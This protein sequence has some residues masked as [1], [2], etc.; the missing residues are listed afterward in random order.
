MIRWALVRPGDYLARVEGVGF[1]QSGG[2][3]WQAEQLGR[4]AWFIM[5]RQVRDGFLSII[6]YPASSFYE[7]VIPMLSIVVGTLFVLGLAFAIWRFRD[8]RHMLLVLE[9]VGAL[10]VLAF[11]Q[12]A[13]IAS[14]R[15]TGV[16]PIF[17]LLAAIALVLLIEGAMRS[18]GYPRQ[19]PLAATAAIVALLAA[20]DL[21]YYF[22]EHLPACR[23]T[24]PV[25]SVVSIGTEY[26]GELPEETTI[27]ALTKPHLELLSYPSSTYLAEREIVELGVPDPHKP[28]PG[29]PGSEEYVFVVP[30]GVGD[31][32]ALAAASPPTVVIA[33]PDRQGE[34]TSLMQ[35][36]PDGQR[37][38]LRWC[39]EPAFEVLKLSEDATK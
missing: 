34:L 28:E 31:L 10:A 14:Y 23:Y 13:T 17:V 33:V 4:P 2:L 22:L 21:S 32:G 16:M 8:R 7:A 38:T 35:E 15:V 36:Y 9:V 5:L 24:D 20:Y 19:I 3:A 39:G 12:N 37:T 26:M 30:P 18:L 1:V 27:L 6:A 25:T 11:G 29:R